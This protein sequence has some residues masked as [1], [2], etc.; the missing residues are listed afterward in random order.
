MNKFSKY[1]ISYS[2]FELSHGE[3]LH[4]ASGFK[5]PEEAQKCA[6][7]KKIPNDRIMI[8]CYEE[9]VSPVRIV[10]GKQLSKKVSDMIKDFIE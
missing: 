6:E 3:F 9:R 5:T 2:A 8:V 10:N 4:V 1:S 7:D